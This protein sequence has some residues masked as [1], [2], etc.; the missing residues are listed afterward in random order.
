MGTKKE[1]TI[2]FSQACEGMIRYKQAIG[3]SVHTISDYSVSFKKLEGYLK[4][5][6]PLPAI[7]RDQLIG[8]FA[9]L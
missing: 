8:F 4:V 1:Q 5:D 9:Y 2:L 6:P 3:L 7:T